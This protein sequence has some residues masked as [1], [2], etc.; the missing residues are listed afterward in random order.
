MS[1]LNTENLNAQ[2]VK[3]IGGRNPVQLHEHQVEAIAEMN[4]INGKDA[5][6]SILVLPTGGGKTLTAVY[7]LLKNAIDQKKKVLWIATGVA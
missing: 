6:R 4:I 5:F 2:V 3:R 1:V 7:W